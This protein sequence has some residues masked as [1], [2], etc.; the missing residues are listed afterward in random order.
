MS[1]QF[2]SRQSIAKISAMGLFAIA[3]IVGIA[4]RATA[5][6]I[7]YEDAVNETADM[8]FHHLHRDLHG[9]KIAP[10]E[11]QYIREW[12][13]IH[14]VVRQGVLQYTKDDPKNRGCDAPEWYYPPNDTRDVAIDEK[15]ADAVFFSR[16][17]GRRGRSIQ[18]HEQD[19]IREW[20]AIKKQMF[21]DICL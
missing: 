9:R 15:L 2:L 10:N 8:L 18:P 11:S 16:Y 14:G 4:G 7:S 21:S 13:A 12:Q 1:S 3:L 17:P 6:P 20:N 19:A 5:Y